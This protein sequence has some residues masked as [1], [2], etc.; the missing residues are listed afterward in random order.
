VVISRANLDENRYEPDLVLV[1]VASGA[2]RKL[3]TGMLGV[4][5]PRWSPDGQ[6]LAFMATAGTPPALQ[7]WTG[8]G[9]RRQAEVADQRAARRATDRVVARF[10]HAGLCGAGR[11]RQAAG[12]RALQSVL[13]GHAQHELHDDAAL[14][15]THLW[16]V[17]V[18]G[19]EAKRLTSGPQS[20]PISRPPGPPAS[21]L[22]WTKGSDSI[23]FSRG[24]GGGG[25]GGMQMIKVA[26]G[27]IQPMAGV[28]GAHP[29]IAPVGDAVLSMNGG[30]V[31]VWT[32][33][34][35]GAPQPDTGDRSQPR[36]RALAARR[37]VVHRRR[38]RRRARV[39]SGCS[40]WRARRASS[41]LATSARRRRSTWT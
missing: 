34:G 12:V 41:I 22:I 24:G 3:V 37:Q 9:G 10:D 2:Q 27:T 31:N 29:Q 35:E 13:R 32:G 21:G 14:P 26:D 4:T 1:D 11:A 8:A 19:G 38:Q 28:S 39:R 36:A 18:A 23:I 7:I 6:S 16:M 25:R 33:T 20:L 17:R 15:P 40:R 30:N 5:S